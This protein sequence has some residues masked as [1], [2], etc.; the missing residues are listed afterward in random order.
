M[1]NTDSLSPLFVASVFPFLSMGFRSK[2]IKESFF[3]VIELIGVGWRCVYFFFPHVFAVITFLQ[4]LL[5]TLMSDGLFLV[6]L[7]LI[8]YQSFEGSF[9]VSHRDRCVVCAVP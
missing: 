1:N 3:N 8:L 7:L 6:R 5:I 2:R 9:R 4:H